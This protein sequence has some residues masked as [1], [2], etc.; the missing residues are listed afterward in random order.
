MTAAQGNADTSGE[1]A[2][3]VVVGAG[4]AGLIAAD[5]AA[6]AG[7]DV[8]VL[9]AAGVPGGCVARHEVA[10]LALDAGAESFATRSTAVADLARDLGLGDDI[11]APDPAGAWIA[12]RDGTWPLPRAGLLGIPTDL[13]DP[14]L[15]AALAPEALAR[16]RRD[17]ADPVRAELRPGAPTPPSLGTVVRIRMGEQVLDRLVRP[18]VSGVHAA[19][20]DQLD[21]QTVAPGLLAALEETGSLTAGVARLRGAAKAGSS[22]GSLRGGMHRLVDA[23]VARVESHG[24]RIRL[25]TPVTDLQRAGDAWRVSTTAAGEGYEVHADRVVLAAGA[26]T[27]VPLLAR[28]FPSLADLPAPVGAPVTLATLVVRNRELNDHPRGTGVLVGED[29]PGIA[30]KALTHATAKWDWLEAAAGPGVHVLRLSY[31]RPGENAARYADD[32]RVLETARRDAATLLGV[33]L[34]GSDSEL[35]GADVVRWPG[36]LPAAGP[37]HA[38][39]VARIRTAARAAGQ[40]PGAGPG[41]FAVIGGWLAGNGLAAVVAD[42][43]TQASQ[44]FDNL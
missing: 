10:G 2:D 31:G 42:S 17:A 19:D 3:V 21:A 44:L 22:V 7:L 14:S 37:G 38:G 11:I 23:L 27:A 24:G 26:G 30:A 18:V 13:D 41:T 4:I 8:L 35:L 32:A 16:A 33:E 20:P 12:H 5:R 15:Q 36:A 39:R 25:G 6:A 34:D 43:R 29:A 40:E 28:L 9:D 1:R